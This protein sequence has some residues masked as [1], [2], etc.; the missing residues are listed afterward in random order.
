MNGSGVNI[1]CN[2]IR[3]VK[4]YIPVLLPRPK[5]KKILHDIGGGEIPIITV[6]IG[7]FE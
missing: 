7:A 6:T 2:Y 1:D 5:R 3:Y 4:H